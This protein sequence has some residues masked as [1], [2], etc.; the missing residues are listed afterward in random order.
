M[1][2]LSRDLP[3]AYR[4]GDIPFLNCDIDFSLRPFIPRSETEY[5]VHEV[6]K[7]IPPGRVEILDAFAG[8]GCIG[9]ALLK[10]LPHA[11]VGF[12]EK[13]PKLKTQILINLQK[14]G[15]DKS[16]ARIIT[17][18]VVDILGKTL[19]RKTGKYDYILTN[20][21]YIDFLRKHT[22]QRSVLDYEPH[23]ALFAKDRGLY[24]IKWLVN[25][26]PKL[27][28]RGGKMFIEFGMGQKSKI[29]KYC[30]NF[31]SPPAKGE[32]STGQRGSVSWTFHRDQYSRWRV[33]E[34]SVE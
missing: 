29:E 13:N 17:G 26:A 19:Q 28:K 27:L 24:Y 15:I 4:I 23:E 5:W 22:V 30:D 1:L 20:P 2:K 6:M 34:I 18:D 12:I 9:V 33:L 3:E 8:S 32:M 14:N 11:H 16:R 31:A 10:N 25:L 7:I 21:P